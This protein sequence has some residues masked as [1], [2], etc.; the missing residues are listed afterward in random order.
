MSRTIYAFFAVLAAVLIG[1]CGDEEHFRISG[2]IEGNPT[3]N[4]RVCYVAGGEYHQL[5]TAARDGAFEFGGSAPA[6]AVIEIYDYD[7]RLLGRTFAANGQS[8]ELTL[9]RTNHWNIHASGSDLAAGWADF[10]RANTHAPQQGTPAVDSIVAEYVAAHPADLLSTLLLIT[11]YNASANPV[12]ADSLME[13]ID[14]QARPAALTE[15]FNYL[16]QRMVAQGAVE[17]IAPFRYLDR[18]D[19]I[20]LFRASDRPVSLL[21]FDNNRSGRHDSIVP[22]LSDL[23]S[24]RHKNR[25]QIIEIS[26]DA[27]TTEWKRSTRIDTARWIQAW[28]AGGYAARGISRLAI[29]AVPYFI[30]ADSTGTQILR[31]GRA[32]EAVDSVNTL[33]SR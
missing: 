14:P 25:L 17:N 15:G 2:T 11:E 27:D 10:L 6:G 19:S 1:S 3:M 12:A 30:V 4:L 7:N 18:T 32:S 22:A 9:D 33:I 8:L 5:I 29:P 23:A 13:Q 20:R 24:S 31:T 21:V 28:G 26:I 16:L